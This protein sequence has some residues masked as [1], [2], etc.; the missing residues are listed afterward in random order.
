MIGS[1]IAQLHD[2]A[3]RIW[4]FKWVAVLVAALI[5]LSG[6]PVIMSLPKVYEAWAQIYVARETPLGSAAQG[7]GLVGQGYGDPFVVEKTL[8]NDESLEKLLHRLDP[9]T[10]RLTKGRTALA[11]AALRGK[12]RVGPSVDDGFFELHV[13]DSDPVRARNTAQWLIDE[14]V[15][16]N[17]TRNQDALGDAA[18]FLDEQIATYRQ[19]L[20]QSDARL[21]SFRAQHPG[22]AALPIVAA[23]SSGGGFAAAM[24]VA[25]T[26][27]PG[28][29]A[30]ALL[31]QASER[32]AALDARVTALRGEYTDEHPDVV[33]ARR[34]LTAAMAQRAEIAL[35]APSPAV[36][37]A[38]AP[39][40][41]LRP[42]QG[43]RVR[44][45]PSVSPEARAAWADLNRT[46]LMLRTNYD[47]LVSRREAARMSEAAYGDGAGMYQVTRPPTVPQ[48]PI[49]PR[50]R[51][52][53]L[54][55][56]VVA[57]VGGVASAFV[58]AAMRGIF[59]SPRELETTLGLP[60]VGTVSW[61]PAWSTRNGWAQQASPRLARLGRDRKR[62]IPHAPP[63]ALWEVS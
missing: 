34:Q 19:M 46:D 53:L 3:R 1:L 30:S 54:A 39:V 27:A 17:L 58:W 38:A 48:L 2:E 16:R 49:G 22:V 20:A 44:A 51:L 32:V 56:A 35:R 6:T 18:R 62:P 63:R 9:N 57:C 25:A 11:I 21:A 23:P 59:V 8:L 24:P 45:A 55:L 41:R 31:A 33:A 12:I 52:Y 37:A 4:C 40:P 42:A 61:E 15:S 26:P 13:L 10:R 28:N 5:L 60:V 47:Q 14:F 29:P 36:A 50:R 43:A 7:V